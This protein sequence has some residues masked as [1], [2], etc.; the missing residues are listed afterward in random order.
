MENGMLTKTNKSQIKK[1]SKLESNS[2]ALTHE[3]KNAAHHND[4]KESKI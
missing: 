2:D 1:I 3:L 4:I